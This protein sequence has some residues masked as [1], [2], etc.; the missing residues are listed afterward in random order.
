MYSPTPCFWS[1]PTNQKTI[2]LRPQAPDVTEET[3]ANYVVSDAA[4][5]EGLAKTRSFQQFAVQVNDQD[6]AL[7]RAPL[8]AEA[9]SD[10]LAGARIVLCLAVLGAVLGF[11]PHNFN[12]ASIFLG[13]CG[14]HLLGYVCVVII[15]MFGESGE[16]HLVFA[17]LIIFAVPIMDTMLAIIRRWL[18]GRPMSVGDDQHMH[19]QLKRALGGVQRAVFAMYAIAAV[20]AVV[21]VSLAAL[22]KTTEL[23]YRVVYA[24]AMVL[25]GFVGVIAVKTARRERHRT[26]QEQR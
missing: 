18:A 15:L 1:S 13:D 8:P 14:S 23:R 21:G 20:F 25:F 16:T 4:Q 10:T 2:V 24:I 19:H 5:V 9:G 12:P 3:L 11:I 17:G 6:A 7:L 26:Q 22:V